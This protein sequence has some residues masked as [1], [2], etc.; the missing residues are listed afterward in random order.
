MNNIIG[1]GVVHRIHVIP[2]NDLREHIESKR[3]WCRPT[4]DGGVVVHNAADGREKF[5]TGERKVS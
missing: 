1:W 2:T 3:C 5:E 4:I